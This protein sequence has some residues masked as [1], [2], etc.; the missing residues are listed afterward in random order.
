MEMESIEASINSH[1]PIPKFHSEIY[2]KDS[3]CWS[4]GIEENPIQG[5]FISMERKIEFSV[6]PFKISLEKNKW[7]VHWHPN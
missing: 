2:Q 3:W 5:H 6:I 4:T 7:E 1:Y